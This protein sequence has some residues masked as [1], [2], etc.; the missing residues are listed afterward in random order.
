MLREASTVQQ[1]AR[2]SWAKICTATDYI[3]KA[4]RSVHKPDSILWALHKYWCF[5]SLRTNDPIKILNNLFKV[6]FLFLS[7]ILRYILYLKIEDKN[8]KSALNKLLK[9][10]ILT[11]FALKVFW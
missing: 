6:D 10:K 2:Y 3:I 4:C 1:E 8:K 5:L 11:T 7:S 9:M